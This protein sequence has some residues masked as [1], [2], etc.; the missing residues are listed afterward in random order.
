MWARE[1]YR[2]VGWLIALT[3]FTTLEMLTPG[4]FPLPKEEGSVSCDS[5]EG[6]AVW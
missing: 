4:V 6:W 5:Q 3:V 2:Q 1:G